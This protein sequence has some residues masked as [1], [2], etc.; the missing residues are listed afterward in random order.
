MGI[1]QLIIGNKNYSSWS[2]RAWLILAKSGI[3]YKEIRV[4]LNVAGYQEQLLKYSPTAKVP[5]YIEDD[6]VI[7]DSLAIAEYFAERYSNLMPQDFK[8]RAMMR[9]LAAEMH[10]GFISLRSLMP[11][12]CRAKNRRVEFTKGLTNDIKRVQAIWNSCKNQNSQPGYWLLGNFTIVDAMYAPV[13]FRF[14][15]Y[16]VQC[17]PIATEYMNWVLQDPDIQRWYEAAKNE[18][19]IIEEEEVGMD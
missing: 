15:T 8:Q 11:M 9:S 18:T 14:K 5:V 16:G 7:W 1:P 17:D 4:P 6:L 3:E 13:V 19:E 2:L 10:S 12:N